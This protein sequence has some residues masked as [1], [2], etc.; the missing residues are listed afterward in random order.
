MSEPAAAPLTGY[1]VAVTA[2]R[3]ADEL[4]ALLRR[5]GA[6][7][8]S[9][10]AISMVALPDDDEL[11]RH[12]EVLIANPPDILIATTG[13]GFRGWIAAA[14]G[15]GLASQLIAAL[16]TSQIV[17]R[18]PKATGA[19]RA[20]VCARHGHRNPN[21]LATYCGICSNPALPVGGSL[22]SCTAPPTSG[23]R[24]P[25]SPTN[26]ASPVPKWCRFG[27]TDGGRCRAAASSTS[28][29]SR[30]PNAKSMRSA[31]PRRPRSRRP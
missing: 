1:R 31:S 3:R 13:I 5:H 9:A 4:C 20:A 27:C 10:P 29:S 19:L 26:Y 24:F 8:C 7:V 2:A 16:S 17:A 11:H 18:G 6:T 14:D 12:T 25:S 21:R 23:T 15:W 28:W 30:S 22:F